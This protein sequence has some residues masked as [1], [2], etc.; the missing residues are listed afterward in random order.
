M[1]KIIISTVAFIILISIGAYF[2]FFQA[3]PVWDIGY[4]II[5]ERA[6]ILENPQSKLQ[7]ESKKNIEFYNSAIQ[8]QDPKLCDG[9]NNENKK[10]ECYD[11]IT[12]GQA[13]REKNIETCD[14][15]SN[16]GISLIC[17][18][19]IR[20][21]RAITTTN[22]MLCEKITDTDRKLYCQEQIDKLILQKNAEANSITTDVCNKLEEE[23]KWNCLNEVAQIDE[24]NTHKEAIEKN[25]EALCKTIKNE[26]L[27]ADC[28]DTINLKIAMTTSSIDACNKLS[29]MEKRTYCENQV[30]KTADADIYR[31]A[32]AK[33][34]TENCLKITNINLRNRCNDTI[35]IARVKNEKDIS[36]CKNLS[37]TN[38]IVSCEQ[39]Q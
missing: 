9:I 13:L 33:S 5:P 38:D 25:D 36:K 34:D 31:S 28:I 6:G 4:K 22:K 11:M 10:S 24:S 27:Q 14:T 29:D 20:S 2:A 3:E 15:L 17:R 16:T 37:H 8:E 35:I 1:K 32:I 39:S 21:D 26:Q 23:Q 12:A 7:D 18:D 30:G 19:A